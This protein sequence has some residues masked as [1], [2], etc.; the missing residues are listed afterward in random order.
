[1]AGNLKNNTELWYNILFA[2]IVYAWVGNALKKSCLPKAWSYLTGMA[3][4]TTHLKLIEESE[5]R[6]N[7]KSIR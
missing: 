6:D 5:R 1:M 3:G 4:L 7:P 2:E